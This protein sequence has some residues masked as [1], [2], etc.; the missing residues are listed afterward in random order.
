MDS[1]DGNGT[2][3][4]R[5]ALAAMRVAYRLGE[6]T[7]AELR[8][9]WAEQF[10]AWF[11]VAAS[12]PRVVEANAVQLATADASGR[13]SVRTV[14]AKSVTTDGLVFYTNFGS[15][16]GHDLAVHPWSAAVF[17]WLPLQRQVRLSGPTAPVPREQTEAYFST[18]P[19]ESQVGAWASAQSEVVGRRAELDAAVAATERRFAG[20]DVLPAPP[21]WGGYLLR[22][23]QVEFWQGRVGRLHDRLRFRLAAGSWVV[24]RLAP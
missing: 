14:L 9:S 16:K 4:G 15:A 18:R 17:A 7:E 1:D 23:E 10:D 2:S 6:L 21:N 19:R 11:D 3:G 12:D 20:L 8:A 5:D 22:P 13:A 24:E